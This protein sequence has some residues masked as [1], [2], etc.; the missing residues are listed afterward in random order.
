M[1]IYVHKYIYVCVHVYVHTHTLTRT[2]TLD[3]YIPLIHNINVNPFLLCDSKMHCHKL[4][5]PTLPMSKLY[6][7]VFT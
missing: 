7:H 4:A 3:F 6:K 2:Y 1:Y 5:S